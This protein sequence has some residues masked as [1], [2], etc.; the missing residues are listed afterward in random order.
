MTLEAIDRLIAG[1]QLEDARA[2]AAEML[3]VPD[4]EPTLRWRLH[5]R[6]ARYLAPAAT[7]YVQNGPGMV[8]SDLIFG[9]GLHFC[10]RI[11]Q[12]SNARC[13]EL[14]EGF[15]RRFARDQRPGR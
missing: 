8:D 4:L 11:G 13:M 2:A 14:A 15:E 1:E 12:L 5:L 9:L 10:A 6:R 7:L 3:A